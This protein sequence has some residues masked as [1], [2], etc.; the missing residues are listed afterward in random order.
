L[1]ALEAA[2]AGVFFMPPTARWGSRSY[3]LWACCGQVRRFCGDDAAPDRAG[4]QDEEVQQA[5]EEA[6]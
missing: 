4:C 5:A 3:P 6:A 2:A 1:L